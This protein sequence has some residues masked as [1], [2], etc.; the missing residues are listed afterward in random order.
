MLLQIL[1]RAER[2][3]FKIAVVFKLIVRYNDFVNEHVLFGNGVEREFVDLRKL[4]LVDHKTAEL[5]NFRNL[6]IHSFSPPPAVKLSG[7]LQERRA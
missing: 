1:E 7:Q 5:R 3:R 2:Q 4:V 6:S